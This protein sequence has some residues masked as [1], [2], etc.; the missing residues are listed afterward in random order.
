MSIDRFLRID[1]NLFFVHIKQ[2]EGDI[3]GV[4]LDGVGEEIDLERHLSLLHELEGETESSRQN[5]DLY[6]L[7][8]D[9]KLTVHFEELKDVI[10]REHDF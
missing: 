7:F 6:N 10:V 5:Q 9:H 4:G 2:I 3:V 8:F 1:K